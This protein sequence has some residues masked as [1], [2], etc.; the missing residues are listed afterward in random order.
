[1]HFRQLLILCPAALGMSYRG[2][3]SVTEA[4]QIGICWGGGGGGPHMYHPM[5]DARVV[6]DENR[7]QRQE[8]GV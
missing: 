3:S 6:W 1:M 4:S 2:D 7:P 8:E 5:L